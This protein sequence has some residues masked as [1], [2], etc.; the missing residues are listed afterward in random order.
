MKVCTVVGFPLGN[1][2]TGLALLF[3]SRV[4]CKCFETMD[5]IAN[6]A[7]EVD[8]VMAIG[9]LKSGDYDYVRDEIQRLHSI[10]ASSGKL[11]KVIIE[12]YP[13]SVLCWSPLRQ[14]LPH[15][16]G[17]PE[18]ERIDLPGRSGVR[19]DV[20]GIWTEFACVWCFMVR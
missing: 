18:G 12:I 20:Y 17:N 14:L 8:M 2:T 10:C 13:I 1:T 19:E 11:L 15:G 6:G 5:A 4:E 16:R 3:C 9:M 7:D